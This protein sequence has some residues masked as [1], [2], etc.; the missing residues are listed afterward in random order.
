[1]WLRKIQTVY[2]IFVC[3]S[4]VQQTHHVFLS[5]NLLTGYDREL[6]PSPR[7]LKHEPD[8]LHIAA[9]APPYQ[10]SECFE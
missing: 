1:M 7:R 4:I 10:H 6:H 5:L 2:I 9:S 3:Y 8:Q